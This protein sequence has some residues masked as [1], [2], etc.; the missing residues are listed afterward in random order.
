[1]RVPPPKPQ[2]QSSAL[3]GRRRPTIEKPGWRSA[4]MCVGILIL[5]VIA[6][7]FMFVVVSVKIFH[8]CG[9]GCVCVYV[10][11]A[12]AMTSIRIPNPL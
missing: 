12:T 9:I 4:L 6:V 7:A 11:E 2:G 10:R 5:T 3:L 8:S 1:M